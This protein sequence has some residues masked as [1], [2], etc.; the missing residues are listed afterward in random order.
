VLQIVLI[1]V[2]LLWL[3]PTFGLLVQSLR[4]PT[5][6]A[7]GGWWH[8]IIHPAQLTFA[9]YE[10]LLQTPAMRTGFINT[11]L[12]TVPATILVILI[13]SAARDVPVAQTEKASAAR[14]IRK[15]KRTCDTM[16]A[17]LFRLNCKSR[18]NALLYLFSYCILL[19]LH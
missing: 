3:L 2:A 17:L 9:N 5:Q 1:I 15:R 4:N 8:A 12:I 11:V 6:Y 13:G 14:P 10:A 19:F 18:H 16:A 7:G